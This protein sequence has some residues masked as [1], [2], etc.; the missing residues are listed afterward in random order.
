MN[1]AKIGDGPWGL[2]LAMIGLLALFC[3]LIAAGVWL[4]NHIQIS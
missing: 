3:I 1:G 2:V 4:Y